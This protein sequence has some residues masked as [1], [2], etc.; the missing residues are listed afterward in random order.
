MRI[1]NTL[2]EIRVAY[3]PTGI[4]GKTSILLLYEESQSVKGVGITIRCRFDEV[5]EFSYQGTPK[6]IKASY[7]AESLQHCLCSLLG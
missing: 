6:C 3:L 1:T 4:N 2:N 7:E 5:N